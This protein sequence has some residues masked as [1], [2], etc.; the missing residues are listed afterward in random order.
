MSIIGNPIMA[1]ASGPAA[2]IFVAGLSETDTV[3]ATNGSKTKVGVWTQKPNPAYV[4]PDGYTQLEYIES[5]GTQYINTGLTM[6]S[7]FH[8]KGVIQYTAI[9]D[10]VNGLFGTDG[11][12]DNARN[13]FGY[14]Y[15]SNGSG[16]FVG[17]G[18]YF[19]GGSA[20]LNTEYSFDVCNIYQKFFCKINGVDVTQSAGI[21]DNQNRTSGEMP[22]F[23]CGVGS[24]YTYSNIKLKSFYVYETEDETALLRNFV[25]AKRN[26]DSVIGLYDLVNDVFYTNVGT[27][28]FIAGAEVPQTFDGFLIKPIRDL[29][30]WTVTATDGINTATQDVLVDVITEYEIEMTYKLWLYKNG[31]E[32]ENVTGGWQKTYFANGSG[33]TATKNETNLYMVGAN[34][35]TW[36]N[37][38]F[39]TVNPISC[40][41]YSKLY[42]LADNHPASGS[43]NFANVT[44]GYGNQGDSFV[45][46]LLLST[47]GDNLIIDASDLLSNLN[48]KHLFINAANYTH[49]MT[50]HSVW[51]E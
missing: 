45:Q 11:T 35:S 4:V 19:R 21:G 12:S 32:F 38:G 33:G 25:P 50:I 51:L 40:E 23:R 46:E 1:G 22:L 2:R 29:G 39:A 28:E 49:T 14:L 42:I 6:E 18:G 9:S 27:G 43:R 41:G 26:S 44:N 48:N 36:G 34:A 20:S 17:R 47:I 5:T 37:C 13:N 8:I 7:G 30:T 15:A 3:T 16:W 31:D 10:G 24:S